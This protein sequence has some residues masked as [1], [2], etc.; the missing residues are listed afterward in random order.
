[1]DI[2]V[3]V[4]QVPDT[5]EVQIDPETGTLI[6]EG[7]PSIVNPFDLNAVEAALKLK[8]EHGGKVTVITMGPPQA[9]DVLKECLAMGAEEA[10]LVS[11]KEF[12][13]A[14]TWAT[15]YTLAK[16]VEAIGNYDLVLCGK[17]AIDGDTAQTGPGIAEHLGIP[18]VTYL[19]KIVKVEGEKMQ[20]ER[21]I[22]GGA[23]TIEVPLPALM[24][25]EKSL[26]E[27]RYATIKGTMKANKKEI[28]VYSAEDIKADPESIGLKGS[29]TKVKR[30][31]APEKKKGGEIIE[32]EPKEAVQTLVKKLQDVNII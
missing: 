11:D 12:A 1:M 19:Q 24:T 9:K 13:G 26:N 31:F 27:P 16:A 8:E 18:Q 10:I 29:P 30:V 32:G 15:S 4:K 6:R 3:C 22:D 20:V 5:T 14:D 7:V 2:I 17:E 28:P 23:E 21:V 25:C